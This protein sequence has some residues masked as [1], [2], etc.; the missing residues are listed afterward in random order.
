MIRILIND[1]RK[2]FLDK[3]NVLSPLLDFSL[4]IKSSLSGFRKKLGKNPPDIIILNPFKNN[5]EFLIYL[6][7]YLLE[8]KKAKPE[9]AL[10]LNYRDDVPQ[11]ILNETK[12]VFHYS[13]SIKLV[14]I[15]IQS[16]M[17]MV[18][19]NTILKNMSLKINLVSSKKNN[20]ASKL[21]KN[22][23]DLKFVL[24]EYKKLYTASKIITSTLNIE[25]TL[26]YIINIISQ[27]LNSKTISVMLLDQNTEELVIK[28]AKPKR[29]IIGKRQK[30]G[31][32]IA[33][34]VA[35][36]GIPFFVPDID[37]LNKLKAEF[38]NRN[39]YRSNSFM[40]VPLLAKDQ[41]IG[42]INVTD[43]KDDTPY[44]ERERRIIIEMASL[45]SIAIENAELY[46]SVEILALED[47]L[48]KLFNRGFF[49]KS[50]VDEIEKS[51]LHTYPISLVMLDIDFFKKINDNFGHPV[52]DVVLKHVASIFK[53]TI[54]KT[55]IAAR[56]GGEEIIGIL[57]GADSM[58]AFT[59]AEKIRMKIEELEFYSVKIKNTQ[60]EI[61]TIFLEKIVNNRIELLI[62]P[63]NEPTIKKSDFVNDMKKLLQNRINEEFEN[64]NYKITP[65]KVT[66]SFGISSFPDDMA[67]SA[68]A[69][70]FLETTNEEDLLL[71]MVDKALYNAK[72]LGRNRVLTYQ[73]VQEGVKQANLSKYSEINTIKA[74][75]Y[76]LKEKNESL[77]MHNLRVSKI[78][79]IIAKGLNLSQ[80][81]INLVKYGAILHDV[82]KLL[83]DS[84][85]LFK[86]NEIT[87]EDYILLKSHAEKGAKL[88][89]QFPILHKYIN[90][91]KLHHERFDGSGY[92][93]GISDERIPL[94]AKII[95]LAD[96]YDTLTN[97]GYYLTKAND[98]YYHQTCRFTPEE[99][100]KQ[101][102]NSKLFDPEIVV[103]FKAKFNEIKEV[104]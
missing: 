82:G 60:K 86:P 62:F 73:K 97:F 23:T 37:N 2:D 5:G 59:V 16:L 48:T 10:L 92:P 63:V 81:E 42:V 94:E 68:K 79:E 87:F 24:D 77:Y 20:K 12:L 80:D 72:K 71:Y 44:D 55:D 96:H 65:L 69:Q 85:A 75:A 21:E 11:T 36:S 35:Q 64:N 93:E 33:G 15:N 28:A 34:K 58:E 61:E 99:A 9:I 88:L 3:L 54:R 29:K 27:M 46:S 32:G 74:F 101:I 52:G 38:T 90:A 100:L 6:Q 66:A 103:A 95:G 49:Q 40:C 41:V 4:E 1:K 30:I 8:T 102:E 47:G 17:Q 56:Y 7:N 39:N 51:K 19:N 14:E 98:K 50:I 13:D 84:N 31:E 76:K 78:A 25:K 70:M 22:I 89:E 67:Y 18:E 53:D 91:A 104:K 43:K 57:V 45:I 83:I 26:Q